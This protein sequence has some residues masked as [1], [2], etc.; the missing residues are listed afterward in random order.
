MSDFSHNK[1]LLCLTWKGNCTEGLVAKTNFRGGKIIPF[2]TLS[3]AV[4]CILCPW[5]TKLPG[6]PGE[7][8]VGACAGSGAKIR[9]VPTETTT[10]PTTTWPLTPHL[11]PYNLNPGRDWPFV[12]LIPTIYLETG[13]GAD[14]VSALLI[15]TQTVSAPTHRC[16]PSLRTHTSPH[17]THTHTHTIHT[18]TPWGK[19]QGVESDVKGY[20]LC[21]L[22][23]DWTSSV[24]IAKDTQKD[25]SKLRLEISPETDMN[26]WCF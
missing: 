17:P 3:L 25:H 18:S 10:G 22:P 7:R 1:C 8:G 16:I 5:A 12:P 6:N 2:S 20:R 26:Q 21:G 4:A 15:Y 9:H 23:A 13:A 24:F 11:L 14:L 19:N